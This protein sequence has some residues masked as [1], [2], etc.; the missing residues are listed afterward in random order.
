MKKIRAFNLFQADHSRSFKL[1][2]FS[3][4]LSTISRNKI[5][6]SS[7]L[8]YIQFHGMEINMYL[9]NVI[10]TCFG[11]S[12]HLLSMSLVVICMKMNVSLFLCP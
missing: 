2:K 7:I 5:L 9:G 4:R 6:K 3:A 11:E 8:H 1:L 10:E 12:C